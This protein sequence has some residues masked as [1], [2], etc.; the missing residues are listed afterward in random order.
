MISKLN[1]G[2]HAL[3]RISKLFTYS[4]WYG[5]TYVKNLNSILV[6]QKK[7]MC[8]IQN[9]EWSDSIE[10]MFSLLGIMTVFIIYETIQSV[11]SQQC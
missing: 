4:V 2:L 9:L 3:K 1:T 8:I 11:K 6:A 7:A 5:S 10:N